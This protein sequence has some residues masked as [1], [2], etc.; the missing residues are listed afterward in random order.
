M[1]IEQRDKIL[2]RHFPSSFSLYGL[3]LIKKCLRLILIC[4]LYGSQ[5][6]GWILSKKVVTFSLTS[7]TYFTEIQINRA[8]N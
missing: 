1:H 6:P 4:L 3:N 2:E 8:S 5:L 7:R